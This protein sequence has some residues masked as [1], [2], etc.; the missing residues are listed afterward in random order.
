MP[1]APQYHARRTTRDGVEV[2]RLED[3]RHRTVVSVA[4]SIGNI[5]FEMLVNGHNV[6]WFPYPSVSA[7]RDQPRICGI[8]LLAPWADRLDE[9]AFYANGKRYRLNLELGNI[10]LDN[11]GHPIHGFLSLTSGWQVIRLEADGKGARATSRLDVTVRPEWMAQFPFAHTIEMTHSLK[12][13][14]LEVST[15]VENR[16][17]EPMPL[18]IGY[19]SFYQITD[20]SRDDWMVGLGAAREWPVDKDLLPTGETRPLHD[21]IADP[22]N[23]S[24]RGRAFDNV[25]A[26]LI[27]DSSG[28]AKFWVKG[29][30]Q[31]I[32]V[33][34]G[35]G[36]I[37][38]EIW[39]PPRREFLCFEPMAGINNALNLAHRGIYKELQSIPP[40]Q[41][42]QASFWIHP[43]GF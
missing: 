39:A 17:A 11:A 27:R 15:Q 38:G 19:H 32:E 40:G 42:W 4:P 22:A 43:S 24:L 2:I 21:L 1:A 7:F 13:G 34:F 35:P 37:A 16:S 26:G 12:D 30:Q 41:S 33:L 10:R 3:Q 31:K 9:T 6:L 36:F 28:Q 14:V 5:A 29:K 20:A 8:P 18:S 25:L 23:F